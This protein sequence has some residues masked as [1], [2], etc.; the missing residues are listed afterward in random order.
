MKININGIDDYSNS[1]FA[2]RTWRDQKLDQT[3]IIM[4]IP[5]FPNYEKIKTWRQKLREWP[6]DENF[7]DTPPPKIE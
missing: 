4:S 6:Q 1:D 5:D 3:D 7:P 2:A